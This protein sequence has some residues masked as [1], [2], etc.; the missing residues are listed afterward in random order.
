NRV[1]IVGLF[2]AMLE[3]IRRK[4]VLFMQNRNFGEIYVELNPNPPTEEEP[5]AMDMKTPETTERQAD[6]EGE[7]STAPVPQA[8]EEDQESRDGS[9]RLTAGRQGAGA[10]THNDQYEAGGAYVSDPPETTKEDDLPEE[11]DDDA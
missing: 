8:P 11:E 4:K 3:L 1:E 10:P 6:S 5:A 7:G 9:T 2:I